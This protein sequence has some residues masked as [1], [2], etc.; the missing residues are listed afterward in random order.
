MSSSSIA[1]S[2]ATGDAVRRSHDSPARRAWRRFR[3]NRLG[4]AAVVI[5]GVLFG[6]SLLAEVL[7]ND[8]PLVARYEGHWYFPVLQT[9]PEVSRRR[10]LRAEGWRLRKTA[11]F[12]LPITPAT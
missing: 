4:Y 3:S 7:S 6:V 5:L 11:T 10:L 2:A 12:I 9:L 1:V 8:K